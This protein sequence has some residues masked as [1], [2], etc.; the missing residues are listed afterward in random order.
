MTRQADKTFECRYAIKTGRFPY[1]VEWMKLL[2]ANKPTR[3]EAMR[4]VV[5]RSE[6]RQN[7][8]ALRPRTDETQRTAL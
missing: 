2:K 5:E 3:V 6:E 8:Q 1:G 4:W 7:D